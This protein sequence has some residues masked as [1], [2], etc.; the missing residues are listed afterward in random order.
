MNF[1]LD[2]ELPDYTVVANNYALESSN[3]IHSDDVAEDYGFRGGLVPGVGVYAYMTVPVVKAL[4]V[5][6]LERGSMTGKFINP[7]YHG[8]TVTIKSKVINIDPIRITISA[9]NEAGNLCAVG[10][11]SLPT[12]HADEV[13]LYDYPLHHTPLESDRPPA[14]IEHLQ[15]KHP[16]G[17]LEYTIDLKN[18]E[19][20]FA[21][22]LDEVHDTLDI[23]RNGNAQCHPALVAHQANMILI[24][25]VALGPWIHTASDVRHHALPKHNE[26]VSL[27]GHIA[28]AYAKRGHEIVVMDL[29]LFGE[30]DRLITHLTHTAIIKPALTKTD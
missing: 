30:A 25:N 29:A 12:T 18:P 15:E 11:A 2:Q 28:H 22:F 10:E 5:D 8:E 16:L 6:W 20:E 26:L 21:N 9:L 4:G 1:S 17:T 14:A 27:R 13:H 19:G 23:Y 7:V 3:K 24:Q